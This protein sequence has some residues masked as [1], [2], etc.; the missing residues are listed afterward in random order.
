MERNLKS[1]VLHSSCFGCF[2]TTQSKLPGIFNS[3][4]FYPTVKTL[5]FAS[6]ISN[7]SQF[8]TS[9]LFAAIAQGRAVELSTM[10]GDDVPQTDDV[11]QASYHPN[12]RCF[13]TTALRSCCNTPSRKDAPISCGAISHL[14]HAWQQPLDPLLLHLSAS[15]YSS[16]V[17]FDTCSFI[18]TTPPRT[19]KA[20]CQL[21]Q[22]ARSGAHGCLWLCSE[23]LVSQ[24]RTQ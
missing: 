18:L 6:A 3:Q 19:C 13:L 22:R 16:P 7:P 23:P 15:S 9:P 2:S 12:A 20:H 8:F 11:S 5:N 4:W 21:P 24:S 1:E 17:L 10:D 14:T